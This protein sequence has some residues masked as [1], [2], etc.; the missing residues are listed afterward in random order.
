LQPPQMKFRRAL[1]NPAG[2]RDTRPQQVH[3]TLTLRFLTI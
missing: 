2:R 1:T 3:S